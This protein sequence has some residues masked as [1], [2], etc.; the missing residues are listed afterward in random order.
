MD[1]RT[2]SV[3]GLAAFQER[4]AS[5]FFGRDD[6]TRNAVAELRRLRRPDAPRLLVMLGPSGCGKSSLVRAGMLPHLRADTFEWVVVDVFR[7][8]AQ[9]LTRMAQALATTFER[10]RKPRDWQDI[11]ELL[12]AGQ[13]VAL[14]DL[15]EE[16]R[17]PARA[18]DARV[19]LIVDQLEEALLQPPG[20]ANASG[21]EETP[22]FLR[23]LR[24]LGD[25]REA[26]YLILST[27]RSDFLGGFQTHPTLQGLGCATLTVAPPSKAGFARLIEGPAELAR[28]ELEDGLAELMVADT[29]TSDALPLLAFTLRELY[30]KHAQDRWLTIEEYRSPPPVGLGGLQGAL[31]QAAEDDQP[32]GSALA[33]SASRV[34]A[35]PSCTWSR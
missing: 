11:R 4:D 28:L 17:Y 10:C 35:R 27:L 31:A 34:S 16:L 26:A 6:D 24:Q 8:G 29:E 1:G 22:H 12:R 3:R 15:G 25:M 23:V 13:A 30:E 33:D 9:P 14:R 18:P 21:L 19:L 32:S 2:R 20:T 7:P 5:V